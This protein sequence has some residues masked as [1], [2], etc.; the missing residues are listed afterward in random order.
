MNQENSLVIQLTK[1]YIPRVIVDSQLK[2]IKIL[3]VSGLD[4]VKVSI[5]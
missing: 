2:D 5:L 1:A 4:C 3:C